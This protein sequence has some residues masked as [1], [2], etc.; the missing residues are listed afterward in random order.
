MI[1]LGGRRSLRSLDRVDAI[2]QIL[3]AGFS[4]S[5]PLQHPRLSAQRSFKHGL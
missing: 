3:H 1:D 2:H 5:A 4:G